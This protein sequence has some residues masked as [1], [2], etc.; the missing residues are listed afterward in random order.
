MRSKLRRRQ[1]LKAKVMKG[2]G[3]AIEKEDKKHAE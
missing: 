3:W 1:E 2:F